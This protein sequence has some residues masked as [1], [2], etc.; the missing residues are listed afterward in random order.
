[1]NRIGFRKLTTQSS[2]TAYK[3]TLTRFLLFCIRCAKNEGTERINRAWA[4]PNIRS[5]A[6]TLYNSALQ[7]E[8]H[9]RLDENIVHN[10]LL[11]VFTEEYEFNSSRNDNILFKF[12]NRIMV[13]E[14]GSFMKA[15]DISRIVAHMIFSARLTIMTAIKKTDNNNDANRLLQFCTW[16]KHSPLWICW[17]IKRLAQSCARSSPI[18]PRVDWVPSSNYRKLFIDGISLSLEDLNQLILSLRKEAVENLKTVTFNANLPVLPEF[19]T[20][21]DNLPSS[22]TSYWFFNDPSNSELR[23]ISSTFLRKAL[24][25]D[26]SLSNGFLK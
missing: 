18:T 20:I 7:L 3:D 24:K 19:S 23:S 13:K 4:C 2:I 15:N 26:G 21:S 25:H 9:E 5:R 14:D 6:N 22:R 8:Q 12:F 1:L 17:D 11:S 16:S 10:L